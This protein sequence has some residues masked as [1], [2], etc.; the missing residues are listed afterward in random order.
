MQPNDAAAALAMATHIST[1]LAAPQGI[2]QGEP[3]PQD[4]LQTLQNTHAPD[5]T[6]EVETLQKQV[7]DL[8]K[9]VAT[10]QQD[11]I[12]EMRQM[13]EQA[14]GEEDATENGK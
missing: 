10:D 5:L 4:A 11:D 6:A 2:P 1:Q 14:L 8:Q 7:A 3:Q 9:Q 13:I 12:K